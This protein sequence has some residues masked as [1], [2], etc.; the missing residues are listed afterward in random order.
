MCNFLTRLYEF[1]SDIDELI[2]LYILKCPL[3]ADG[4]TINR[5]GGLRKLWSRILSSVA[6][7][8]HG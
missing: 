4:E 7:P 8:S 6:L 3:H 5:N 1:W 2:V